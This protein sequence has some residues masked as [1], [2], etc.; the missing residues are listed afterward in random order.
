LNICHRQQPKSH[1]LKH[2]SV[3]IERL[4][5]FQH[6]F[7]YD[8]IHLVTHKCGILSSVNKIQPPEQT[9]STAISASAKGASYLIALQISSRAFTFLINQIILR[10]SSPERLGLSA[11]LELYTI[12]VL[13]FARESIRVAVQRQT[14]KTQAI[15]NISYISLLL[16]LPL[17]VGLGYAFLTRT[18]EGVPLVREAVAVCAASCV[19]ELLSE[20]AFVAAQQRLLYGIRASVETTATIL[21]CILRLFVVVG[22]NMAGMDIGVMSFAFGQLIYALSLV[23]MYDFQIWRV[24]KKDKFSLVLTKLT[25]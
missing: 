10:Y 1:I 19:V 16:G 18:V 8:T 15:V 2:N 20:P 23:V 5:R 6:L 14:E 13:Y 24:A 11:Q 4:P 3:V 12:T 22:S 21:S 25:K 17:S 9:M 7:F